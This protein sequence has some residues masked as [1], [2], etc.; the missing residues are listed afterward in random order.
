MKISIDMGQ[1]Q[2]RSRIRATRNGLLCTVSLEISLTFLNGSEQLTSIFH[3]IT[4]ASRR[5]DYAEVTHGGL[6]F[7]EGQEIPVRAHPKLA[8]VTESLKTLLC[9]RLS[10][11]TENPVVNS[12]LR[13]LE[14]HSVQPGDGRNDSIQITQLGIVGHQL[15]LFPS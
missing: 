6:M 11:A 7:Y 14:D 4:R 1:V 10:N 3:T 5:V 15:D 8:E 9:H 12:I 2:Y 13:P